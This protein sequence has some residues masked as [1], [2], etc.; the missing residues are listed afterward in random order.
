MSTEFRKR[1][2]LR[3][4]ELREEKKMLQRELADK[5]GIQE[6]FVSDI[7]NGKKEPCLEVIKM[8]AEGLGVS[9]R[10]LFWDL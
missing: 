2:G 1:F 8:I 3:V 6:P 9:L 5:V 10:R 7:E 4:R